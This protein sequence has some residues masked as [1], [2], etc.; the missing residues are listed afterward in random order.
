MC[1]V[2]LCA[3]YIC[4]R[5]VQLFVP[6]KYNTP[7]AQHIQMLILLYAPFV[8]LSWFGLVWFVCL[9][10][11]LRRREGKHKQY[12]L[13]P[14]I[15]MYVCVCAPVRKH[16]NWP[17]PSSSLVANQTMDWNCSFLSF[18]RVNTLIDRSVCAF[19]VC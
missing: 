17:T 3:W 8:A 2:S 10:C 6:I 16:T 13:I 11:E 9:A 5:M 12:N 4:M 14:Y 18:I 19:L 15:C 7:C 1:D